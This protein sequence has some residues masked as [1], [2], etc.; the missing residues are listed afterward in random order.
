[1]QDRSGEV[2]AVAITFGCLTWISVGLRIFVR[3]WMLKAFGLDDWTMIISQ[4]RIERLN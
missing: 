4:G 3:A 2:L 1:M